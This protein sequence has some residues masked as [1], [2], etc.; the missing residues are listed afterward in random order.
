MG[1]I[2]EVPNWKSY[3]FICQVYDQRNYC[4][5]IQRDFIVTDYLMTFSECECEILKNG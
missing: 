5:C 1:I 3:Q 2:Y 4:F